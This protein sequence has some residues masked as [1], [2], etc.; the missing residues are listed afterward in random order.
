MV[1]ASNPRTIQLVSS[2]RN[3][4][5]RTG[6]N[7]HLVPQ[8]MIRRFADDNGKLSE[9]QKPTLRIGSRRRS[10]KGILYRKDYYRDRV[11]DLDLELLT[12]IEQK[13]ALVYPSLADEDKP[14]LSSG[15][16]GAA[17]IDWI[18]AMLTRTAAYAILSRAV[19]RK[20]GGLDNVAW[21]VDPKLMTN[22]AR[23]V[24]FSECQD[25]LSRPKIIWKIKTYCADDTVVL[26]DFP[27]FQTNSI[28]LDS[29]VIIVPLA[30]N[31]V[32]F[33][34]SKKAVARWDVP[35]EELNTFL[36]AYAE[37]SIFAAAAGPLEV[38]ARNLR[39]DN[40]AYSSVWCDAARR[41]FFGFLDRLKDQQIPGDVNVSNW[42][43][44]IKDSYGESVLPWRK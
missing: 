5:T 32:L 23:T 40:P 9:L 30:K 13:F 11:S 7:Q 41:P 14:E 8:M 29:Q 39:G 38:V 33:G 16:E 21:T 35:V 6:A 12:P 26:T 1:I 36:S 15:K 4:M 19:A 2:G 18:A 28:G 25:L 34:G 3:L 37:C 17:L 10:P 24:W 42:W 22:I 43:D 31:R 44:Q 27:V 20:H